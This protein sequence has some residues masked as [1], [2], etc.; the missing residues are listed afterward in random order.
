VLIASL[1]LK[2]AGPAIAQP[3]T[4]LHSFAPLNV[5]PYVEGAYPQAGLVLSGDTLY[6]T[7]LGGNGSSN[8]VV[9]AVNTDKTGFRALHSFTA[10][11]NNTNS[12]GA[13]PYAGLILSGD[14]LYGTASQG[15]SSGDGT[16]FKVNTVGTGFTTLHNFTGSDGAN[17]Y[18]GLILVGNSLYGTTSVGGIFGNGT[19]FK[20]NTDGTGFS[21][22]YSFTATP[23]SAPYINSDGANPYAGLILWGNTLYGTTVYGGNSGFGA[24]FAITTD[25]TGFTVLH[26]FT[27]ADGLYP[28]AG[29]CLSGNTLYGTTDYGANYG[30]DGT[31]FKVNTDGTGYTVL[32]QFTGGD[33]ANPVAGL[34]LSGS[35]LY[36]TAVGGSGSSGFGTVFKVNTDGTGF[37]NLHSFTAGP[38]NDGAGP[39]AGLVLSGSTLY[40][41]AA[42]GG[43]RDEGTVFKLDTDGTGFTNLHSF[44]TPPPPSYTNIDG[45]TS[46]ANLLFVGNTL[47]GTAS[48]GG[49]SG[50]G[51]VFALN[52]DGTGFVNL[53][54]FNGGTDGALPQAGLIKFGVTLYGTA[55]GGGNTGNGAV[56]AV[57]S[58]GTGFTTLHSFTALRS[59]YLNT[60]TN[61]DGAHPYAGLTLSGNALYG[62][63]ANGGSRGKGTVFKLNTD[64]TGFMTL[65]TFD[66]VNDGA[67][68]YAGLILSSNTL[69]GTTYQGPSSWATGTVFKVNTDGTGFTTLHNFTGNQGAKLY[70]GLILSG[71]VLYGT[72]L[73]G[74]NSS[75]GTIF[76]V[77]T[78][79]TG[80]TILHSFTATSSS[81]PFTS[82]TN[83]DGANPYVGL[84]LLSNALYGTTARGGSG[85]QGTVFAVNTDGTSF[86]TIHNFTPLDTVTNSDGANPYAG[87]VLSGDTLYGTAA[88]GG[89]SGNG[90]VFVF[91]LSGPPQL[92]IFGFKPNISLR[93]S[94]N[95]TGYTLQSTTNLASQIWMTNLPAP[96]IVNGQYTVTF[97]ISGT[98]QFFRLSQ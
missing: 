36:G 11:N 29:L 88:R 53:H 32:Y 50:N 61:G 8:G 48:K 14:T 40:G 76:K 74:G 63:A 35:T 73:G 10:I 70:A 26:S 65:H 6:G 81:Y 22:L 72:A 75:D 83:S 87:L 59:S 79:G 31:V 45:A 5:V 77:N 66:G 84:I 98:R 37:T 3:F 19:V 80:F 18:S 51:T 86:M 91:T 56:F 17:P 42:G 39:A 49:D 64:G 95:S 33:G 20:L 97:P 46:Y 28:Y 25:G 15:G 60:Y 93:W 67:N 41:T 44:G 52:P 82:F 96:V 16:V 13:N 34:V 90:T 43:S 9:F 62:T 69:Y 85:G 23:A 12:D 68:P 1:G 30:S 2:L 27:E 47:Y 24:V 89:S 94:T 38:N 71:N 21:S 78:D 55:Y 7:A 58:D 4:T 57:N 92:T 54:S